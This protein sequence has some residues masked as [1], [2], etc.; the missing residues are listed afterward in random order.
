MITRLT[1]QQRVS[2]TI[3][4][5]ALGYFVD[6]FDLL[7][8]SMVR[9]SSLK[10]LGLSADQ[11]TSSGIILQNWQMAGML[12]GGII[13]GIWGDKKGRISVLLGTILLYSLGN[14]ANAF[15]TT[16][17]A[18]AAARFISGLGLAGEIGAG[19]TLASEL[20]P[21]NSRG[22]GSTII[23]SCGVMAPLVAGFVTDNFNWQEAYIIGGVLG[24]LLLA[25]R[26]CV[27][28][29]HMFGDLKKRNE[30]VRGHFKMLFTNRDRFLR[31]IMCIGCVLPVWFVIGIIAVFSPEIGRALGIS[32]PLKAATAV[33]TYYVGQTFG[34]IFSGLLSQIFKC[35]INVILFFIIGSIGAIY[36][37]LLSHGLSAA[38]FY[39]LLGLAGFFNGY[40]G[41][42]MM[43]TAE[44]FGTNLRSTA[45]T[46]APNFVRASII[47]D[48][49]LVTS[50]K[51]FFS[52][53]TSIEVVGALCFILSLLSLWKL[54]ETFGRDLDFIEKS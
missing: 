37:I 51:P 48:S 20:L 14:I 24:L 33:A 21:K 54:P 23:V 36:F 47:I 39:G 3:L 44:Q 22:Y 7:L 28:E 5:A 2:L 26:F 40:W 32:T 1:V 11:V 46:T 12:L 43:T 13:W 42:F 18:Y 9:V 6:V 34:N 31:Y 25:L 35:R 49:S 30:V 38:A 8:F 17:P 45:T 52:L 41:L 10:S 19:I 16:I 29:S 53:I 27:N 15:V 50:L 4:V